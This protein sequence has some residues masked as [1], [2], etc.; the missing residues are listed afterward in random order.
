MPDKAIL[1]Y[2]CSGTHG[3]QTSLNKSKKINIIPCTLSDHHGLRLDFNNNKNNRKPTDPRK[4]N[5]SLLNDSLVRAE[6]RK[7]I[8]DFLE[9]NEYEDTAYPNLWDTMKAVLKGKLTAVSALGRKLKRSYTSNLTAHLKTLEQKE[10]NAPNRSRLWEII[11]LRD[12]NQPIRNK[13]DDTKNQ[14]NWAGEM[15]RWLRALYCSSKGPGFNSQ[16]HMVAHNH[17]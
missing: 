17:P 4:W 7:D 5:N 16:Q 2:I 14:Q 15:A 1:C 10:A 13:E 6:I 8:K 12:G 9:F 11:K 3:Y